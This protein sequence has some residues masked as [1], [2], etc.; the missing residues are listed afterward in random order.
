MLV[1][2]YITALTLAAGSLAAPLPEP[3]SCG[4]STVD[5]RGLGIVCTG[6]SASKRVPEPA[7][8]PAPEPEPCTTSTV[9]SRGLGIVCT[10]TAA[11]KRVTEESHKVS[12]ALTKRTGM[13][14][15][16]SNDDA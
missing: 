4:T 15:I 7:P 14:I 12:P 11:S 6:A 9:D 3:K 10:K 1:K 16:S 5:S 2:N 8:E 13:G